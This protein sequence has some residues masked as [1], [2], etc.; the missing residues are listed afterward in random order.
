[1]YNVYRMSL[2]GGASSHGAASGAGDD[3]DAKYRYRMD[4]PE[5]GRFIIINNK[6]FLPQTQMNERSGT[7]KDA[8]SLYTDFKQLGFD[9]QLKHN[10]TAHQMLQLMIDGNM[11][12]DSVIFMTYLIL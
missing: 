2:G 6:T 9:V 8:A 7:D 1:M 11:T 4:Y 12:R 10:Q 5:R 3:A